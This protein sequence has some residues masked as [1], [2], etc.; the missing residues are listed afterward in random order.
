MPMPDPFP[1]LN[2]VQSHGSENI[3][4]PLRDFD[5]HHAVLSSNLDIEPAFGRGSSCAYVTSREENTNANGK[6]LHFGCYYIFFFV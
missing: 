5:S 2:T 3:Y 6:S 4:V 1:T